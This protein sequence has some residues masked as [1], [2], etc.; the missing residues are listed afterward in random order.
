MIGKLRG[1]FEGKATDGAALIEVGGVSYVVHATLFCLETLASHKGEVEV[2]THMAV[3]EDGMDLYGFPSPED[4]SFFRML[5]SVSGIGPKTALGVLNLADSRTLKNAIATGDTT[6]LTRVFGIGKKS[7]ERIVVEL[8]DKLAKEGYGGKATAEDGDVLDALTALGYS[9]D[10]ARTAL[11]AAAGE[12]GQG[13][14][15]R[16]ALQILG[17]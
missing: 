8:K 10:E 9:A 12:E 5:L 14:R 4:L 13:E 6:Y 1:R 3:R 17:S 7:A 15:L 16:K 11:K 2:Y